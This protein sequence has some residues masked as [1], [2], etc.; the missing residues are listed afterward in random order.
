MANDH[1][2]LVTIN[3]IQTYPNIDE[4]GLDSHSFKESQFLIG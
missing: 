4:K 1:G 2:W 3:G